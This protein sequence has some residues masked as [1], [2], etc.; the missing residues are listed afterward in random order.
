MVL[1]EIEQSRKKNP[2]NWKHLSRSLMLFSLSWFLN[3]ATDSNEWTSQ[4]EKCCFT[5]A[6][7][8]LLGQAPEGEKKIRKLICSKDISWKALGI[9]WWSIGKGKSQKSYLCYHIPY[10]FPEVLF[11]KK[12]KPWLNL[13]LIFLFLVSLYKPIQIFIYVYCYVINIK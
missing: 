8:C 10:P 13:F 3:S 2:S 7:A 1:L 9:L 4:C 6:F 11:I 12:K 5:E